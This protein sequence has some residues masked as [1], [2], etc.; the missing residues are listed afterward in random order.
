MRGRFR[1]RR[2]VFAAALLPAGVIGSLAIGAVAVDFSHMLAVKT[3]LQTATDAGALAG[4]Q[5]L[6]S[7]LDNVERHALE[8]T[9]RNQAD[10][11]P[12]SNDTPDTIVTVQVVPP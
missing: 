12:V 5:D 3:E 7:D 9:A 2:G 6:F 8:I 4:A 11:K 10:G 1:G